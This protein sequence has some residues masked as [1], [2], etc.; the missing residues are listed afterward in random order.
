[1]LLVPASL[2]RRIATVGREQE[3]VAISGVAWIVKAE[4]G[5]EI[6]ERLDLTSGI[7]AGDSIGRIVEPGE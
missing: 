3:A 5:H 7:N 4:L 6:A 1:M 2:N